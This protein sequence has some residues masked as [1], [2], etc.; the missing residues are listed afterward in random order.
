MAAFTRFTA[1]R[2]GSMSDRV[3][4]MVVVVTVMDR[5]VRGLGKRRARD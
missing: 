2:P 3:M 1:M 5:S 4:F